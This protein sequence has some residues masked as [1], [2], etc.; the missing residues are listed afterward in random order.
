MKQLSLVL[1]A[2]MVTLCLFAC[3][4]NENNI[5]AQTSISN[6]ETE[7]SAAETTLLMPDLPDKNYGGEDFTFLISG[8]TENNW[9]KN[10]FF[11]EDMNGEPIN[12]AR[13]ERNMK[14]QETY[15]MVIKTVEEY[16][17]E[18]GEKK[19]KSS[20]MAADGAFDAAM[21]GGYA[22]C[23]LAYNN[24]LYD[25]N[26]L[27]YIDLENPWWD[28]KA[29]ADLTINGRMFYTTGDIS[30]V[31]NDCTYSILFNKEVRESYQLNDPYQMVRDGT[32]TMDV[33]TEMARSV[34]Q[35]LNGDGKFDKNDR[36]GVIIWDDTMMGIVNASGD[37]C[38]T[39]A[40]DG[41]IELSLYNERVL[42]MFEKFTS[43]AYESQYGY[44]YQRVSY[45]LDDPVNMFSNQQALF[46]MQLLDLVTYFRDMKTDFGILPYPK[47]SESQ[48]NYYH[49]IGS[50]HSV[51]LCVPVDVS[52][53]ECTGIICE[54]LAA[55]GYYTITPAYYEKTL[56]GKFTRDEESGEMLDIILASRVY[57][58]GWYYQIGGYNEG[59]MNLLRKYNSDF[60]SMYE[61]STAAAQTLI[62]KI[63]SAFAEITQ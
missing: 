27:N 37:K 28:Q 24:L 4:S 46:F 7:A 2:V 32:W 61:K 9:K 34:S 8:N 20:I 23:N 44:T 42:Q 49:T 33:Y 50:W 56:V 45:S 54:A 16:G 35:D 26:Q 14:V 21:L 6:E 62:D 47:Y 63:N 58:L 10:D 52:D 17:S 3:A 51:F 13:Y 30:T 11:A 59:I 36:V 48:E 31:D 18:A 15:G 39:V 55:E 29:N 53:P 43:M 40:S 60:T 22:C 19:L 12:D 5:T 41:T 57:D 38:C 25:L 1:A